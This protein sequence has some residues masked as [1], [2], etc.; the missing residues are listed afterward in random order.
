[1]AR[2]SI[3]VP[4]KAGDT[5]PFEDTLASILRNQ[6]AACQI[7]VVHDGAYLDPHDLKS[8]GVQVV[9][10]ADARSYSELYFASLSHCSSPIVHWLRPGVMVDEGWCES[11]IDQFENG[12]VASVT[13]LIVSEAHPDRILT[14]G[15]ACGAGYRLKL[16]G[17]GN[18]VQVGIR[19]SP[20]GPTAWAAFYRRSC[21]RL[22]SG[23]LS[24]STAANFDLELALCFRA[25]GWLNVVDVNSIVSMEHPEELVRSYQ[26][27]SGVDTQRVL[28]RHHPGTLIGSM[29]S[30]V[31][32]GVS[33]LMS[34]LAS[35]RRGL[36]GLQRLLAAIRVGQRREQRLAIAAL[37][38]VVAKSAGQSSPAKTTTRSAA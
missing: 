29:K 24:Q 12:Q 32:A 25:L 9:H 35:P 18:R 5:S 23:Q 38:K 7:V 13:P 19:I 31:A 2:L 16:V 21:L 17:T 3:V 37:Q 4:L 6:P 11:A 1:M 26:T 36:H 34:S 27:I 8:I 22:V 15:L 30:T 33:E 28:W 20:L 10:V 14:A